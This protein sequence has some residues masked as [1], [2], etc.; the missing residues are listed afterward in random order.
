MAKGEKHHVFSARTTEER[1]RL[2]NSLKGRL[3]ISWD[4]LVIG[5]ACGHYNLDSSVLAL[6]VDEEREKAKAQK[7]A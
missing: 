2:L 5:A 7:A 3:E 4:T 6:P 1:L